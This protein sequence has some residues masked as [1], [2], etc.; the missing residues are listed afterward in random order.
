MNPKHWLLFGVL[1]TPGK[2]GFGS[3]KGSLETS[4]AS[5]PIGPP[6]SLQQGLVGYPPSR[7]WCSARLLHEY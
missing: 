2:S 1:S 5:L 4:L 6:E 3:W 7:S